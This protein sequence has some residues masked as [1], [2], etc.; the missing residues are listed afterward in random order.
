MVKLWLFLPAFVSHKLGYFFLKNYSFFVKAKIIPWKSFSWNHLN[1]PNP[2]GL[3]AGVDKKANQIKSWWALGAG[4]IEVGTVTPLKQKSNPGITLKKDL[5]DQSLWNSMGFP[6]PG[7]KTF[8]KNLKKISKPY[9]T[10]L[11]I[12]IGKQRTTSLEEA[13][14]DYLLCMEE[15]KE[16]ADAF[17]INISSPNTHNLRQIVQPHYFK[18]FLEKITKEKTKPLLI[19]ISPDMKKEDLLFILNLGRQFGIDGWVITNTTTKRPPSSPFPAHGGIS[20]QFLKKQSLET[21]RFVCTQL[22][23]HSEKKYLIISVGGVSDETDVLERLKI[24]AH[25]VQMYSSLV[26]E[27]PFLF[28]KISQKIKKGDL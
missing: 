22:K 21:L 23:T 4:F 28:H 2:L 15:L 11:F 20:G 9:K 3:A 18:N 25:L 6:N 26:F 8:K 5:K 16:D 27:G 10:P 1:F 19:K 24:G 14:K 12:N 7:V 13:Y 17:V